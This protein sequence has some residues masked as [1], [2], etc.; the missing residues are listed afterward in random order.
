MIKS[1]TINFSLGQGTGF[2]HGNI[3]KINHTSVFIHLKQHCCH[4]SNILLFY[5]PHLYPTLWSN[6][7][8]QSWPPEMVSDVDGPYIINSFGAEAGIFRENW[9]NA[10]AADALAPYIIRSSA[11]MQYKRVLVFSDEG[12]GGWTNR[13]TWEMCRT[14]REK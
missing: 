14:N 11:I 12:H 10:M 9:V 2:R 13:R 1:G 8:F 4:S 6:Q 5:K 3:K 7:W